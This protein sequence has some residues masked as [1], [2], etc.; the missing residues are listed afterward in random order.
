MRTPGLFDLI[1]DKTIILNE[2]VNGSAAINRAR[3][4]GSRSGP[5]SCGVIGRRDMISFYPPN[6]LWHERR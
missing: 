2:L 5:V 4:G 6:M 1:K 3:I